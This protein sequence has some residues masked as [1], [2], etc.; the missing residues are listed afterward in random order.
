VLRFI[1][2]GK[3]ARL[4]IVA[5]AFNLLNHPNISQIN[6]VFGPNF[7]QPSVAAGGRQ[8]QFSIDFEF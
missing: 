7:R 1:P 5:E 3:T 2:F 8:V 4:D 6:P